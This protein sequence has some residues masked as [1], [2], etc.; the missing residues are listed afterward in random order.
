MFESPTKKQNGTNQ[1][2]PR[3]LEGNT[4]NYLWNLM[5]LHRARFELE[6]NDFSDPRQSSVTHGSLQ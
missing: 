4:L 3:G 1:H 5:D 6:T 2:L